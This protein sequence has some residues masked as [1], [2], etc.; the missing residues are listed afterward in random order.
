MAV[1]FAFYYILMFSLIP[2]AFV[3]DGEQFA[4]D[5]VMYAQ[6]AVIISCVVISARLTKNNA[7]NSRV[8]KGLLTYML[9]TLGTNLCI[10]WWPRSL[11]IF[12]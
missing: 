10:A 3:R 1:L 6:I 5:G 12:H 7:I 4:S 11:S 9:G 2:M 8:L